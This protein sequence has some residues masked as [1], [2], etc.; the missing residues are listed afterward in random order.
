MKITFLLLLATGRDIELATDILL[1]SIKQ[2]FNLNH[3]H[4]IIIII[5]DNDEELLNYRL[6]QYLATKLNLPIKIIKESEIFP[7]FKK[8]TNTYYLQMYL[9][10]CCSKIIKTKFYLTLDADNLFLNHSDINNFVT[11]N[12]PHYYKIKKIDKWLARSI[13]LLDYKDKINFNINQT[14]FVF[15]T[16]LVKDM[17]NDI[18]V[19]DSIIINKCSEYTIYYIYLLKNNKFFDNY[20][21]KIYSKFR[22]NYPHNYLKDEKLKK[23]FKIIKHQ[24][25]PI[26]VIQT[27]INVHH[28]LNDLIK[29]FIPLSY[30]NRP[31]I[32][33]LTIISGKSYYKRYKEAIRIKKNYCEYHN[34]KFI[35]EYVEKSNYPLK[36]GWIK[37]YK[38]LEILK[39]YDYVFCSDA[40]VVITNR[41]IR[42]EDIIFRHMRKY[43]SVLLST[44]Y[45][46]INS[47][48]TIWKNNSRSKDILLKMLQIGENPLRYEIDKPF[49]PKG[50]YE[51]PN[52]I[53]LYNTDMEIKKSIKIVPQ[54]EINSYSDIFPELLKKNCLQFI[55]NKLNR[56]NWI[57][58]DFLIHFAGMNYSIKDKFKININHHIKKY[59]SK[60]Y[61][62]IM[63]KEGE[64]FRQIK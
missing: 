21:E 2:Y 51:Q 18:D 58:D 5:K 34:Y 15:K 53:Y 39:D 36:N 25:V 31:K 47:G 9:K 62:K 29:K 43:H 52:L 7:N 14:P 3:L 27:R 41:D 20:H 12:K 13:K 8:I 1:P 23:Y 22:I 10:L 26:T 28:K 11:D 32:A 59:V 46:S 64:D 61:Q 63:K 38:L 40:D 57:Q 48:N 35:F 6:K 37:V 50:I 4:Q 30:F 45:N 19:F 16:S 17:L 49:K 60:Y 33:M 55:N 54:Y 56:N 44:D 42:I 24:K